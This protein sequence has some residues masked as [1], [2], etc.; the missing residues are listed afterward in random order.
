METR[1]TRCNTNACL[2]TPLSHSLP[3]LPQIQDNVG[4]LNEISV[5]PSPF[6]LFCLVI[7]PRDRGWWWPKNTTSPVFSTW[8]FLPPFFLLLPLFP[9]PPFLFARRAERSSLTIAVDVECFRNR[10]LPFLIKKSS[11]VATSQL[12]LPLPLSRPLVTKKFHAFF[13]NQSGMSK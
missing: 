1:H 4:C 7:S 6:F 10:S 13:F 11:G 2:P 5:V 12:P 3:S 8:I 9:P